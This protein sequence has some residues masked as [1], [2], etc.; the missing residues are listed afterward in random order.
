MMP[1]SAK[2]PAFSLFYSSLVKSLA[3]ALGVLQVL[4]V[5]TCKVVRATEVFLGTHVYIVVVHVV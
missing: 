3:V 1:D 5:C 4:V 2:N